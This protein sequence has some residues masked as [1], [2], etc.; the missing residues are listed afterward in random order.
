[1]STEPLCRVLDRI[2]E[3]DES[4][5]QRLVAA[6]EPPLRRAVRRALPDR[7][8]GRFDSDDVMQSVWVHVFRGLRAGNW[9]FAD[10]ERLRAFL[11]TI[12]RRRLV[13]RLRR[14]SPS[15]Q[16]E[17][18][19]ANLDVLPAPPGPRPSEVLQAEELWEQILT[20]CPPEHHE[21]LR[22]R[23]QGLTLEEIA[24][25]TGL[26]EG[27]VRRII[28]GLARNLALRK[29]PLELPSRGTERG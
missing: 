26:H 6:Y 4:A 27:S 24:R 17:T 25:R 7:I 8:R 14:H 3:G 5:T 18:P 16:R 13:S 19:D 22:L 20:L 9:E 11:F 29:E 15:A 21:L 10:E 1:M 28:R 23:R 2:R 12:A